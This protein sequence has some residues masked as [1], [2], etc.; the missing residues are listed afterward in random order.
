MVQL[1]R[2]A[3]VSFAIVL[4]ACATNRRGPEA[5]AR[6]VMVNNQA[7]AD[8]NVYV[9]EG[10]RR[11][12]LGTAVGN[13]TTKFRLPPNMSF[14]VRTLRFQCVPIGGSRAAV[15]QDITTGPE[16]TITLTIPPGR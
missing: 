4:A 6:Y 15:S 7:F 12:R 16:D 9:I 3:L 5:P 11:A 8:M 10:A 13:S 2:L 1:R 14:G